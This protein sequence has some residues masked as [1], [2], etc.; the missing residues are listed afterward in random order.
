M[1]ILSLKL[2]ED[3]FNEAEELIKKIHVSRNAYINKALSFYN[4][5]N[6][7]KLMREKLQRESQAT[8]AS[9]LEILQEM[10]QLDDRL[11]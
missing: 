5:V 7:R 11:E 4:K 2:K 6:K 3:V 10:E 9:S 1:K 8:Q